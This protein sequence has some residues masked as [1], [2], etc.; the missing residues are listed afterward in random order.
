MGLAVVIVLIIIGVFVIAKLSPDKEYS[1]K[2]DYERSLLASS[3]LDTLLA[4]TSTCNG[5]S[6]AQILQ[7]CAGNNIIKCNGEDS[8]S[9]FE[10]EA[11]GIFGSTMDSWQTDYEFSAFYDKENPIIKLGN[12]CINKKS[13]L[14]PLP[15][16]S[17][18]LFVKLDI[19]R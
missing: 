9:Y 8:C 14:F 10:R 13:E 1:Y 18:T 16:D 5:L 19:C 12:A 17:G 11:R 2:E 6:F 4:T 7:D 15:S 3:M